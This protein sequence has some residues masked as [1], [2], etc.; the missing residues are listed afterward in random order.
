ME[1]G[2]EYLV[3]GIPTQK[4]FYFTKEYLVVDVA[5]FLPVGGNSKVSDGQFRLRINHSPLTL[6]T[7]SPG[8]VAASLQYPDWEQRPTLT[9]QAGPVVY[10]P[11]TV[12]RFPGD[13]RDI[14]PLPPTVK[15]PNTS[16]TEAPAATMEELLAHAAFSEH[17]GGKAFQGCVFFRFHGKTKSI[18]SLE[19]VYVPGDGRPDTTLPLF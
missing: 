5:V 11:A 10:G 19:L 13:H 16:G 4:G 18:K 17:P 8:T 2:A 12:G 6:P 1:I 7:D 14:P 3:H 9:A 15:D